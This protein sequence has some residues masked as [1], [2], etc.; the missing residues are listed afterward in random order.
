MEGLN[1]TLLLDGKTALVTGSSRG[2]GKAI[3]LQLAAD[4]AD[5]AVCAR[6]EQSG[7]LPGSIGETAAAI[8][9][10]GRRALAIRCDVTSDD[11]C[12]TAVDL[13]MDAFGKIDI[14]V[15]NAGGAGPRS[16]FLDGDAQGIDFNYRL[17]L[18]APWVLSQLA[19]RKMADAGGGIIINLTSGSARNQA[20]PQPGSPPRTGGFNVPAYGTTKAALD[21]WGTAVAEELM[22]NK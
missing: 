17:N 13:A 20:P 1:M 22:Q 14:L 15:N 21:R 9:A 4:G 18:R 12:R 6:S 11:D 2:I 16:S 10:M 5:I 7:Q 19:G 3:A 8:E